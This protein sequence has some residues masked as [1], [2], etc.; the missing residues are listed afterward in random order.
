MQVVFYVRLLLNV[1]RGILEAANSLNIDAI[2]AQ[3]LL[4]G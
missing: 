1:Q 2:Q 4:Y 3:K